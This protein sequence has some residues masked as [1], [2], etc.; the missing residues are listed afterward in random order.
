[1]SS[2]NLG[3][4]GILI[5]FTVALPLFV[6]SAI[7]L[8]FNVN[9]NAQGEPNFCGGTCGSN[10]NCQA[11]FYCHK[12]FC[13]N[14]ICSDDTDCICDPATPT[15]TI[16]SVSSVKPT[17]KPS[18]TK[19]S[20]PKGGNVTN[21]DIVDNTPE[22]KIEPEPTN[23]II[24][25]TPQPENQFFAKYAIY[26]FGAFVLIVI[27]T[28]YYAVKKNRNNSIPHIMPPINI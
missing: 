20:I 6:F 9:E 12:G 24:Y 8:N 7:N 4:T 14:P 1:M 15:P 23:K 3:L 13:R 26:V 21:I 2:K 27:S 10:Y 17:L 5:A 19:T 16:K 18:P 22:A 28:I 25:T 11:N